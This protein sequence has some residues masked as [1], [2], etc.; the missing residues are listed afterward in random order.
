LELLRESILRVVPDAEQCISYG[1]PAFKV[2]R[3]VISGFA[4]FKNHLAY[5]P[6]RGSGLDQLADLD[7]RSMTKGVAA[8]SDRPAA[9][10]R[11][12]REVALGAAAGRAWGGRVVC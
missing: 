3:K 11:T 2:K 5:L 6:H 10:G 1:V 12:G 9:A 8:L 7:G 4:A